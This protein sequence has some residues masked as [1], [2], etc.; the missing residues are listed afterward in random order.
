MFNPL[1]SLLLLLVVALSFQQSNSSTLKFDGVSEW[2][3]AIVHVGDSISKYSHNRLQNFS[4]KYHYNIYIFH[5]QNAFN[6]CNF[7]Q[8]SLL[9]K[10]NSTSFT[11]NPSR[12]GFFYFSF[13]NGSKI[14]CQQGQKLAIQVSNPKQTIT[15]SP[16]IPPEKSPEPIPGGTVSSSPSYP[17]PF[18]PHE[19]SN[20][21]M[22]APSASP[23]LVA[24]KGGGDTNGMPF[25]NSNP[26]VPLPTGEVDSATIRPI[27]T[28][29]HPSQVLV[30]FVA[31]LMTLCYVVLVVL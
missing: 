17:W 24:D 31:A 5:T 8:A 30:R 27:P 23:P 21:P 28:S 10:H 12:T 7:T 1:F 20:S 4:H 3:S 15:L 18:R 16:E 25:I 2:K 26:A 11:W 22:I 14:P 13:N 29:D 9:N 19:R 6:L